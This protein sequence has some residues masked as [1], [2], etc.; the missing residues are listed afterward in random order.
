M[1]GLITTRHLLRHA[2]AIIWGFGIACYLRCL[3]SAL[4]RR[5][6][7]FL[8]VVFAKTLAR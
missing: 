2:P 8:D 1:E 5:H 7:T 4:T 3:K 6:V